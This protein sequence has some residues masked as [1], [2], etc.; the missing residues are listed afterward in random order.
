MH[1]SQ[2]KRVADALKDR[3]HAERQKAKNAARRGKPVMWAYHSDIARDL[4]DVRDEVMATESAY[5]TRYRES[6]C[7]EL[8]QQP[9]RAPRDAAAWW[10]LG[11][12]LRHVMREA[13]MDA[14]H[15]SLA[16]LRERGA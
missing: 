6:E 14:P 1:R 12:H 3:I 11:V 10:A 8:A 13:G 15:R 5:P 9:R 4:S 2:W 16:W 7:A